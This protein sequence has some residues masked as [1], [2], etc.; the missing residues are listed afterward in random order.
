MAFIHDVYVDN[1]KKTRTGEPKLE[2]RKDWWTKVD[3]KLARVMQA[4]NSEDERDRDEVLT[5]V[6]RMVQM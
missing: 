4:M 5:Y 3:K 6:C 1:G 2:P